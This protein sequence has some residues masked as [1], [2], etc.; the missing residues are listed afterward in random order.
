MSLYG[1]HQKKHRHEQPF[2]F[3]LPKFNSDIHI[4]NHNSNV[5]YETSSIEPQNTKILNIQSNINEEAN[6]KVQRC[7]LLK[8]FQRVQYIIQLYVS[9]DIEPV[10]NHNLIDINNKQINMN[11]LFCCGN[12]IVYKPLP[13][14]DYKQKAINTANKI[15]KQK[16]KNSNKIG[17]K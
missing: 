5:L 8:I 6:N 15:I 4:G 2:N 14:N 12:L 13:T 7:L 11:E 10:L 1:G 3:I 16:R 9:T 17:S